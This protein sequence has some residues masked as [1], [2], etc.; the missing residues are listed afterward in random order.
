[1][2]TSPTVRFCSEYDEIKA[3]TNKLHSALKTLKGE[4]TKKHR[5]AEEKKNQIDILPQ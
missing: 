3:E 2:D 4:Q 5:N 1:M